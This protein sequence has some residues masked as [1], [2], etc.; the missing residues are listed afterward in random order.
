MAKSTISSIKPVLN[1]FK[2]ILQMWIL[3]L[4]IISSNNGIIS[5][6]IPFGNFRECEQAAKLLIKKFNGLDGMK[7]YCHC[8]DIDQ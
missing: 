6:Q 7:A 2:G 8:V 5:E 3:L 1:I 4:I